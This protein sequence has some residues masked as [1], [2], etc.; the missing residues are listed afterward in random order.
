LVD[1]ES[2]D[3]DHPI[4]VGRVYNGDNKHPWPLP[5]QATVSGIKTRSSKSG[6]AS[7]AN[8][9]RFED[10]KGSEY[11]WFQAEKDYHHWVKNNA[12]VT[13]KGMRKQQIEKDDQLKVTGK[14]EGDIGKDVTLKVAT[15]VNTGIGGDLILKVG[16]A[17][18]LTISGATNL[19]SAG[20]ISITGDAALDVTASS[21]VKINSDAALHIKATSG[22]TIDGGTQLAIKAG[23]GFIVLDASGVSIVGPM[24]KINSGG[25]APPA[26]K[27][28]KATVP[29][30][31]EPPAP[32][33]HKDPLAN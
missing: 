8:E 12:T 2:G 15:D 1:F 16:G 31:K 21:G 9:L 27:A 23:A 20:G 18:G 30:A 13:I 17:T 7:T 14:Y 4:V 32:P 5:A 22:I 10:K 6:D 28:L 19:K 26:Q 33:E 11:V 24:V 29:A 25:S 3:P